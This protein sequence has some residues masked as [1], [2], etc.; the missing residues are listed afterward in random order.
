MAADF[1]FISASDKPALLALST[2]EYMAAGRAVLT[3]L[4]YKV[5][6][7]AN[8]DEFGTR[9]SQLQYQ[10]LL[11]EELFA[12]ETVASNAT[13]KSVQSMSMGLRRHA[14]VLL[15]GDSFQTLHPM[16]A[17]QWSVHAVVNRVD[18][19]NLKQ[20][21]QKTVADNDLFLNV[22]RDTQQRIAQGKI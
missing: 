18:L 7:I 12:C 22:Y 11:M 19:P 5:H 6:A 16:Q 10:V 13:L 21:I 17:F 8:H 9:F 20:I 2:P 3:E 15:L 14:T 4:G 1:E